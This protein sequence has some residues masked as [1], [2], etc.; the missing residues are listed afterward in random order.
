MEGKVNVPHPSYPNLGF[1]TMRVLRTDQ[2]KD[3][4]PTVLKESVSTTRR[5]TNY[6]VRGLQNSE[7]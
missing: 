6:L 4:V 2:R 5:V 7:L 1:E 3:F